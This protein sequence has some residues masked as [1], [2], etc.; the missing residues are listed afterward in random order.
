MGLLV[1]GYLDESGKENDPQ[2]EHVCYAGY[3]AP[4]KAWASFERDWATVLADNGV[5]YLHVKEFARFKKYSKNGRETS[6]AANGFLDG[7]SGS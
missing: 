6:R 1:K 4:D 3:I 5:D 2:H 7:S